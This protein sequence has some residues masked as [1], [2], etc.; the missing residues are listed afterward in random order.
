MT[1]KGRR[2]DIGP[3]NGE[4]GTANQ[5]FSLQKALLQT[6]ILLSFISCLGGWSQMIPQGKKSD[7]EVLGWR[8]YMWSAVVRPIDALPNSLKQRWRWLMVDTFTFNYLTTA[9]VDMLAVSTPIAWS[10]KTCD[11]CGIVLYDKTAHFS[12]FLLSPVQ[13][14]PVE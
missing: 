14:A 5:S 2:E 10:L 8:G 11:S 7:V 13:G 1:G 12:G 3:S 9:L 6:E 4:P